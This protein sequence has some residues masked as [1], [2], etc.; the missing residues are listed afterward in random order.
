MTPAVPGDF[1]RCG[2]D[3][4][5]LPLSSQDGEGPVEFH[6]GDNEEATSQQEGGPE[7]GEEQGLRPIEAPIHNAGLNLRCREAVE[8]LVLVEIGS[9]LLH[10]SQS[11]LV[12]VQVARD[13]GAL[14]GE[15]KD[16]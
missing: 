14:W 7:E 11:H 1:W 12:V 4:I 3:W 16:A 8:S 5:G 6:H 13:I 10:I 15:S 2:T 9:D